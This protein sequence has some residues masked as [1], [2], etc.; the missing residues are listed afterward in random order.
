MTVV[1]RDSDLH[2]ANIKVATLT[3][4]AKAIPLP[5]VDVWSSASSQSAETEKVV[6]AFV[7]GRLFITYLRLAE[8]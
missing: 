2:E 4:S 7:L 1:S 5:V 6:K 8:V 3:C